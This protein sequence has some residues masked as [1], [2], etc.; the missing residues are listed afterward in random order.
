MA[1]NTKSGGHW[2]FRKWRKVC[3]L[4]LAAGFIL[5]V[6]SSVAWNTSVGKP[7]FYAGIVSVV[8]CYLIHFLFNRCPNCR[9]PMYFMG[10]V[11]ECRYCKKRFVDDKGNPID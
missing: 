8:L 7:L 6:I 10:P 4:F 5:C 2:T 9:R 11:L 3:Y 1:K